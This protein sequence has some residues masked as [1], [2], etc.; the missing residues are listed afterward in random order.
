MTE[1]KRI[2]VVDDVPD[3]L[4]TLFELLTGEGYAVA[5]ATDGHQ[6]LEIIERTHPDLVVSDLS[7]PGMDGMAVLE[8]LRTLAPGQKFLFLTAYGSWPR[9]I[10]ALDRGAMDLIQKPCPNAEL[11]RLVHHALDEPVEV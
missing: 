6:A 9:F 7:M 11:L 4:A 2:L 10:E 1:K 5:T 8:K 3:T